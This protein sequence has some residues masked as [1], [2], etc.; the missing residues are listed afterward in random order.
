MKFWTTCAENDIKLPRGRGRLDPV[1]KI[2]KGCRVMLTTNIDVKNG[3]AN[4]TQALIDSVQLKENATLTKTNIKD[5][6]HLPSISSLHIDHITLRHENKKIQPN[7]FKIFPKEHSFE[8]KL[9]L[10]SD[11]QQTG[12]DTELFYMKA[13][14]F[15]IIVNNA[16]TGHKLQG[17]GVENLF[18][19]NWYYVTNWVYVI[20]SRVK[21]RSGLFLRNKL[22]NSLSKYSVP[23]KLTRMISKL[24][25]NTPSFRTTEQDNITFDFFGLE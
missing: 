5:D 16:T 6:L 4:G 23:K 25:D 10:P 7:T 3:Q 20:L 21:T 24:K 12:K 18:V 17:S 14:Q 15:Q 13:T 2:Y 8:C 9:L 22:D 19:H 1:L 11:M